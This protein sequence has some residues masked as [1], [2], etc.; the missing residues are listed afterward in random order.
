[1]RLLET[2]SARGALTGER[3]LKSLNDGREVW[4]DGERVDVTTHPA[5][6][7][8]LRELARIYDLQHTEPYRDEMTFVSPD[9]G[10]RVS[11][12]YLLPYSTDDLLARRRNSE[13]W[14]EETW[15][16]MGRAPDFCSAIT[17]GIYDF[18]D[19]LAQNDPR[20]GENAVNYYRYAREHDICLT[21]ALGDPQ[22][23]RTKSPS[24]DPDMA[25]QVVRETADG[26]VVR[27]AKQLATLAPL[28]QEVLVYLSASFALREE[29]SFVQ[30][31]ALP[32][33]APGLKMVCREPLAVRGTGYSHP[34][35][36]RFDE[37]DALLIFDD[38]LV[39]WERVFLLYDGPMARRGLGRI[40]PWAGY[41]SHMRFYQRALTTVGVATLIAQAIGIDGYPHVRDKLGEM[42]SYL[43]MCRLALRGVEADATLSP[44]GLLRPSG[45]PGFGNFVAQISQRLADILREVGT[46]G[47]LMQPSEA[48]LANPELRPYLDRYMH[49]KEIGV[50]EKSRLFRLGYELCCDSFGMRQEL[51]ERLHRGDLLRNR[52]N[53]YLMFDRSRVV[54]RIREMISRPLPT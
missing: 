28:A 43:E 38:V 19:E 18:R 45:S 34:F 14:S 21:H 42:I 23:D 27:G 54:E 49:G 50:A 35:A 51:Y 12:S 37:Q 10:N 16:Q 44:G 3:Y 4:L 33:N 8:V 17:V 2:T 26:I 6:A 41:A 25:L 39:P 9:T 53:L 36:S 31:F 47:L 46:S 24:Q 20:F 29:R 22:I 7:G 52:T 15:G 30:W 11:L 48:A 32:M 1:M 5:F 13:I 40:M